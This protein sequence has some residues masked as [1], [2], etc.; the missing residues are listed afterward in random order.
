MDE[1]KIKDLQWKYI[2]GEL[3]LDEMKTFLSHLESDFSDEF[4]EERIQKLK[5][6]IRRRE[7][8]SI[9][10]AVKR[11]EYLN[12]A[13]ESKNLTSEWE[14]LGAYWK[15]LGTTITKWYYKDFCFYEWFSGASVVEEIK[16][17]KQADET[18]KILIEEES[19]AK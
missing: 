10:E 13:H 12:A 5:I 7:M 3:S 18:L 17:A 6:G 19:Y 15:P 16:R 1:K 11:R 4:R 9:G 2:K 14:R 8:I